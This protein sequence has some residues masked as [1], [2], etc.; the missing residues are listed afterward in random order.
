MALV[1][2][3]RGVNVGGNRVFQPSQ[4][5]K[6]LVHLGVSNVGAAGTFIITAPCSQPAL[7]A[8]FLR[9]LAFPAELMICR[10]SELTDLVASEPFPPES[11]AGDLRRFVSIMA[12]APRTFPRLPFTVPANAQWQV[13]VVAVSGR[14]VLAWWRRLGRSFVDPNGV[15]EKSFG[16]TATTRNWNTMVRIADILNRPRAPSPG[17]RRSSGAS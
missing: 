4:L 17:R 2:F 7:R 6:E 5:A 15:V 16:G 13:K 14:F 1:A 11:A 3:M 9:R 12:K 10:G 8:E